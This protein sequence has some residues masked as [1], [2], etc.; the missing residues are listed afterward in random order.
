MIKYSVSKIKCLLKFILNVSI[1]RICRILIMSIAP[2]CE[3]ITVKLKAPK[4]PATN[5]RPVWSHCWLQ[6]TIHG[7]EVA[8]RSQPL[9]PFISDTQG[10]PRS[11]GHS[12]TGGRRTRWTWPK[13]SFQSQHNGAANLFPLVT[14]HTI[15]FPGRRRMDCFFFLNH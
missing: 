3:M 7:L 1:F 13:S 11:R 5:V 8:L 14:Q 12:K 10:K 9:V 4:Y 6:V 2:T 15:L